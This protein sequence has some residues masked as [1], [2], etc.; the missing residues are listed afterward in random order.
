MVSWLCEN[1]DCWTI[2]PHRELH[3][4]LHGNRSIKT[5]SLVVFRERAHLRYRD[6]QA[7]MHD[8]CLSDGREPIRMPAIWLPHPRPEPCT[9]CNARRLLPPSPPM[10]TPAR[11]RPQPFAP[12]AKHL[13]QCGRSRSP[14]ASR[15]SRGSKRSIPLLDCAKH[16]RRYQRDDCR[17]APG[18]QSFGDHLARLHTSAACLA[19]Q[20][21][22]R[23]DQ[24]I[25]SCAA[26]RS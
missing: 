19:R 3:S 17:A 26:T 24:A 12:A 7:A 13:G 1:L 22:P 20:V 21:L 14:L 15:L 23:L 25:C 6:A 8:H 16:C 2:R 10:L 5:C 4:Y 18:C 11:G 9:W